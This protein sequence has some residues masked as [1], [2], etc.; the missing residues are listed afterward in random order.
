[1][2]RR[3]PSLKFIYFFFTVRLVKISPRTASMCLEISIRA[4]LRW[5]LVLI[6]IRTARSLARQQAHPN[7]SRW[8]ARRRFEKILFSSSVSGSLMK[9]IILSPSLLGGS[10]VELTCRHP[11]KVFGFGL[12]S[13]ARSCGSLNFKPGGTAQRF[14]F[15]SSPILRTPSLLILVLDFFHW[16]QN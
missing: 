10:S 13:F 14:F 11:F 16:L 2:L 9:T 15:T 8:F 12:K 3:V 7:H 4:S 6:E 1:M 5:L